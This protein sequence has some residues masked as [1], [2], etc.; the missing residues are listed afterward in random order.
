MDNRS[1]GSA[2]LVYADNYELMSKRRGAAGSLKPNILFSIIII[3]IMATHLLQIYN[4]I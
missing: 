1:P 2:I 3:I 4:I